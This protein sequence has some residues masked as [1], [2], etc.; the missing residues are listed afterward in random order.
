MKSSTELNV[1]SSSRRDS[2]E[3]L[4]LGFCGYSWMYNFGFRVWA[5][6]NVDNYPTFRRTLQLPTQRVTFWGMEVDG[7]GSMVGL[8]L[9]GI[10]PEYLFMNRLHY[11]YIIHKSGRQIDSSFIWR[12][13]NEFSL[14]EVQTMNQS[15]LLKI[16]IHAWCTNIIGNLNANSKTYL[17]CWMINEFTMGLSY[18]R[19]TAKR[20]SFNRGNTY[21]QLGCMESHT[22]PTIIGYFVNL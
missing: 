5:T 13:T 2:Q 4:S 21:S 22:L 7:T 16:T 18:L 1:L 15:R 11:V 19:G 6:F 8:N 20:R 12:K 3:F 10:L 17:T 9:R 14:T